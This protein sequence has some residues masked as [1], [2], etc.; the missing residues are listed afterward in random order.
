VL[1]L[2]NYWDWRGGIPQYVEWA[3][4]AESKADFYTDEQIRGWFREFVETVLER[5]NTITGVKYR[6]D[7]TIAMWELA[8][9]PRAGSADY[10]T[11]RGWVEET[12]EFG[13]SI[14]DNH[15]V[16]TGREGFY[17][18]TGPVGHDDTRYVETHSV[19]AMD[20]CSFHMYPE[21]WGLDEDEAIEWITRHTADA[22]E[23]VGKPSYLGEFGVEVDRLGGEV[24]EGLSTR[25]DAYERWYAAMVE[26]ET[27]GAM[28]WDLRTEAEYSSTSSWNLHAIYPRDEATVGVLGSVLRG[29]R[30]PRRVRLLTGFGFSAFGV[31]ARCRS[32]SCERR[33]RARDEERSEASSEGPEVPRAVRATRASP[34]RHR[35]RLG[36]R[37][38]CGGGAVRCRSWWTERARRGRGVLTSEASEGSKDERSESFGERSERSRLCGHYPSER[39]ERGYPAQRPRAGRG[40][41][42]LPAVRSGRIDC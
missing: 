8:N 12:G 6:N 41:S 16:S 37:V 39:S 15:L 25:N 13:K 22:N 28:V 38:A 36:R 29:T 3:D 26:E 14:D 11:Y 40:L 2:A 19:D 17:G 21:A 42:A 34:A 18:P 35:N 32:R 20:A 30:R 10:A 24:D 33:C 23:E 5:E 31:G 7:P 1:P 4:D 9:E 27:D